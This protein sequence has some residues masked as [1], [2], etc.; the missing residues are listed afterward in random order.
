MSWCWSLPS[1]FPRP[2]LLSRECCHSTWWWL[3][4]TASDIIC[5]LK[6][7]RFLHLYDISMNI[8]LPFPTSCWKAPSRSVASMAQRKRTSSHFGQFLFTCPQLL[9][10][11]WEYLYTSFSHLSI[12][13]NPANLP[14]NQLHK[15]PIFHVSST[16]HPP[17]LIFCCC[18]ELV[19]ISTLS[20]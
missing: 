4:P 1:F 9:S 16:L 19:L 20:H 12:F 10:E 14:L 8:G 18:I 11:S 7:L 5:V 17:L 3:Y 2:S 15:P 13:I 6:A